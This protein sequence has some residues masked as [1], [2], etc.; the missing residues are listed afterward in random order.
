MLTPAQTLSC[1]P[2]LGLQGPLI[3]VL[4]GPYWRLTSNS[5]QRGP[6]R[7]TECHCLDQGDTEPPEAGHRLHT[8]PLTWE[9]T[10]VSQSDGNVTDAFCGRKGPAEL[11]QGEKGAQSQTEQPSPAA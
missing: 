3:S 2:D 4:Q 8:V 10:A 5:C 1:S 7:G 6:C 9:I 11:A